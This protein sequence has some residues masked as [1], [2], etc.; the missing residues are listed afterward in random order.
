VPRYIVPLSSANV[1]V[2]QTH[3]LEGHMKEDGVS[4]A[5]ANDIVLHFFKDDWAR[6]NIWYELGGRGEQ[7]VKAWFL[8]RW[9][10]VA[11]QGWRWFWGR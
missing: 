6:E 8:S 7:P 9:M 2:T 4:R 5:R 1:D 10:I 3:V 11:E